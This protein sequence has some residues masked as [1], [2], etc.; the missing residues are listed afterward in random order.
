M[1]RINF[2][3]A[4]RGPADVF[5]SPSD[6]LAAPLS[7][8]EKI[9]VLELWKSDAIELLRSAGEGMEG[10]NGGESLRQIQEALALLKGTADTPR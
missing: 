6:V 3:K 4:L 10:P 7:R 8:A 2:E 1:A 9:K 5:A